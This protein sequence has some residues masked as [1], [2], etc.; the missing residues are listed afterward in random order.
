[1]GNTL[2]NQL[3]LVA[4][5]HSGKGVRHIRAPQALHARRPVRRSD[6]T[7]QVITP[8]R[9]TALHDA[10]RDGFNAGV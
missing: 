3:E 2:R 10:M 6:Q 8:R 7:S 5:G 4:G 1:M 9:N